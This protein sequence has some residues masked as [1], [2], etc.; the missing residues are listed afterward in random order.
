MSNVVFASKLSRSFCWK[1][2]TRCRPVLLP[3]GSTEPHKRGTMKYEKRIRMMLTR[4]GFVAGSAAVGLATSVPIAAQTSSSRVVLL[5]TKGGPTP[6]SSRAPAS[7]AIV[8]DS[9]LYLVDCPNGVSGQ[10]AKA[11]IRLNQ[12]SQVFVTHDHSDHV[13]DAGSLVVLAWG[14]GLRSSVTLHGPPPLRRIV[15]RSLEAS[16][17]DIAAR[18]REEG[19]PPL[20][21]LIHVQEVSRSGEV[22]R[23]AHVRVTCAMV[24]HFTVKPAFASR[25]DIPD[26]SIVI[27]GDT[28]YSE[29]LIQL[30]RG[31]DLLI[32][33]AMYL[34]GVDQLAAGNLS[35]KEHL[36]RS[37]STTEQV[38]LV[39]A[40][41]G[42]GKLVLSH[43]VPAFP[44]ITDDMWLSGVRK[45][46]R[47]EAVV[48]RDLQEL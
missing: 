15:D 8:V 21:P 34:P 27:S 25:F 22:Y 38:G 14:S 40:R 23:D 2:G 32:H 29:H 45:N 43:L 35:L 31:A 42:V 16:D 33:E 1:A 4:R 17:Y 5:G 3:S 9:A 6:S 41:A 24:D 47:G 36:L 7:V 12:L 48:G 37:H 39:A 13:L 10:L 28:T 46:F 11:G 44:S 18:M 26:R 30:A 20:R 19:R